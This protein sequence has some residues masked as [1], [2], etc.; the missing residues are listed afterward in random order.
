MWELVWNVE[1]KEGRRQLY[2]YTLLHFRTTTK[3]LTGTLR[4]LDSQLSRVVTLG[5]TAPAPAPAAM[6]TT[7][8]YSTHTQR[9]TLET[10]KKR[11]RPLPI[12]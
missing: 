3:N 4:T 10:K 2:K 12:C 6:Q 5:G 11:H 8:R 1:I 7:Q 9:C